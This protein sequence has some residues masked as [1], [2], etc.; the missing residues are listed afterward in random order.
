MWRSLLTAPTIKR[1]AMLALSYPSQT[2]DISLVNR[3]RF[4]D[5]DR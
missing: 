4:V 2:F 1:A 3:L 5:H